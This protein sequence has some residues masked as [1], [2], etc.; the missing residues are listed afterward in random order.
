VL[1]ESTPYIWLQELSM[2]DIAWIDQYIRIR[3]V[4]DN[5]FHVEYLPD[6]D[7]FPETLE[8]AI[9]YAEETL[10]QV[11]KDVLEEQRDPDLYEDRLSG[12]LR[13]REILEGF[14]R[15]HGRMR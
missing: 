3:R 13:E 6:P 5:E 15:Q 4:T 8:R 9:D 14:L 2:D 10:V 12:L 7:K 1:V 11:E